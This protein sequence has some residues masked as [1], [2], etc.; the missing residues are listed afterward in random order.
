MFFFFIIVYIFL[1]IQESNNN[2]NLINLLLISTFICL[3]SRI[4]FSPIIFILLFILYKNKNY[5]IINLNNFFLVFTGTMWIARTFILS[6][7][8][9]FPIQQTCIKTPWLVNKEEVIFFVQEAMRI[10]RTLPGRIRVNDYDFTIYSNDWMAPWFK[11]YFM[12]AALLQAGSAI[13]IMVII[14]FIFK[15]FFKLSTTGKN[16]NSYDYILIFSL[17]IVLSLWF[18]A[19]EIRYGWGPLIALPCFVLLIFI[20]DLSLLKFLRNKSIFINCSLILLCLAFS[21][22]SFPYYNKN[23]LFIFSKK[24]FS[25]SNI[26]KIGTFDNQ[27]IYKSLN[28]QCADFKKI[29]VNTVKKN[30]KIKKIYNYVIF[31]S[32]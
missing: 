28:W 16:I 23:D 26:E 25:Y 21:T 29:C 14:G 27:D 32:N 9:F 18:Q 15:S 4:V 11:N 7:C 12:E 31:D 17:L 24:E 19:P 1:K 5:K 2:N 22:K 10:S 13:I 8:F 30:Y 20:K 3:T 6:G